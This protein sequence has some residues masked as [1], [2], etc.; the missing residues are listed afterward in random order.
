MCSVI[1][2]LNHLNHPADLH[3][4]G[5]LQCASVCVY[6]CNNGCVIYSESAVVGLSHMM[7]FALNLRDLFIIHCECYVSNFYTGIYFVSQ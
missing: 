6:V 3:Y 2:C 5:Q 1:T 4:E 7:L